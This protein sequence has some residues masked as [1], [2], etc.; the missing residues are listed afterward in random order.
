MSC[1]VNGMDV[2]FYGLELRSAPGA[3]FST[4]PTTER[5]VDAALARLGDGPARVADVG[6]GSGAVA[7]S[8]AVHRPRVRVVATD[9]CSKAVGLARENALRHGVSGRVH[10]VQTDL[11]DGIDGPFDLVLANLPYL[12]PGR[13]ADFPG[14][15]P[16]AVVSTGDGL[17]HYRRLA[18]QAALVL[19]PHGRVLVQ[20]DGSVDELAPEPLAA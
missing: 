9:I 12:P 15:P 10:V 18:A 8:I 3:V 19:A 6:S 20:L 2:T 4:R 7:V 14:E 16:T 17:D 13:E 5:L 1:V 11:L